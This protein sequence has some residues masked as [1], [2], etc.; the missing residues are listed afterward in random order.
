MR[1]DNLHHLVMRLCFA[2][3]GSCNVFNK[4]RELSTDPM[5][6]KS[7]LGV[8][9]MLLAGIGYSVFVLFVEHVIYRFY[10]LPKK[11]KKQ[12]DKV[13]PEVVFMG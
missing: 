3:L 10:L 2:F 8:F 5:T 4:Q 7:V 9:Y 13:R 6:I 1:V 11:E 12:E